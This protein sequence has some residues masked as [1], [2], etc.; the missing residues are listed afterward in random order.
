MIKPQTRTVRLSAPLLRDIFTQ[1]RS[2]H[3][4]VTKGLPPE[5]EILEIRGTTEYVDFI[6]RG[7]FTEGKDGEIFGITCMNDDPPE[8]HEY[9]DDAFRKQ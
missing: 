3:F 8:Q 6:V 7:Y 9:N 5:V 1:G 4:R 2:L